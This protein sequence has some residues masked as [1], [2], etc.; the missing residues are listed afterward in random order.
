MGDKI[1]YAA[2]AD[3]GRR[4]ALLQAADAAAGVAEQ[5]AVD[6]MQEANSAETKAQGA[7]DKAAE[8]ENIAD[9]AKSDAQQAELIL[10]NISKPNTVYGSVTQSFMCVIFMIFFRK[11]Q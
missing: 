7:N 2:T 3:N 8:A 11:P 4:R 5:K 10:I 6:A 1:R 9:G